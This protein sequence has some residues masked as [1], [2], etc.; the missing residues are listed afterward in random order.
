MDEEYIQSCK[1]SNNDNQLEF[2]EDLSEDEICDITED[3]F[4]LIDEHMKN[5]IINLSS[6]NF[7]KSM[8]EHITDTIFDDW[9]EFNICEDEQESETYSDLVEYVESLIEIYFEFTDIPKR[10]RAY[11]NDLETEND[12]HELSKK[13]QYLQSI[14]QPAQKT[15]EWYEFRYG[16]ISA[17]NL[18]KVFGSESQRNSLIYEKCQPINKNDYLRFA[19]DTAMHWGNKY[20][21]VT[22]MIYESMFGTKVGEFGCIQHTKYPFIGAS[23]DGINIDPMNIRYGRML[24]IKNIVNREITGIPKEEYW[25]QTQIQME[26]CDLDE[27]DFMETRFLEYSGAVDF[28][29][30]LE[31]EYRGVILHFIERDLKVGS[32]PI[33]KYMPVDVSLDKETIDEWIKSIREECRIE[34]LVL[35]NTI[36]WYLEEYSCVLIQRNRFWFNSAVPKIEELWRTIERERVEGYEHRSS[37]KKI[38]VSMSTDVSNSYVINNMP[39]QNSI[40]LVKLE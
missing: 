3:I 8:I 4:L 35:F 23:P 29:Q 39:L 20:E 17:S 6:P 2:L 38:S 11:S 28:Y 15:N 25:V 37:K 5:E 34:G 14:P 18:W 33:Y 1:N 10:A 9:L 30:D 13:I 16:L 32:M 31:R 22:V 40:C 7:Y 26:V 24:E 36:Y 27:C 19:T 21:P 12:F